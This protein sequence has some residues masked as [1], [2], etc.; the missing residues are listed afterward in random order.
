MTSEVLVPWLTSQ[1]FANNGQPLAGGML[2]SYQAGT[3]TPI[4]TFTDSTGLVQNTNPVG[5]NARGEM[6]VWITNNV[7]YRF[8]LQ[9]SDGNQLWT[10]DQVTSTQL[11]S[12]YGGVD[13]GSSSLYLLN[14]LSPFTSYA[15]FQGTPIFFIPANNSAQGASI[16][17]NG[18]GVVGIYNAN[19][20]TIGP[21]QIQSSFIT[22]IVYQQ[23]IGTSGNSGFV[24]LISGSVTG[25]QVGTFGQ[26]VPIASATTTD[27]GTL[28]AHTGFVTGNTTITSF[29]TSAS[30]LAPFY[31]IRFSAS[32]T[33]T[34]SINLT[35]PG[36]ASIV[37][38]PGDALLAQYLGGV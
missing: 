33:L 6:S 14:F 26:E 37:T 2:W 9:D 3:S 25:S 30:L 36:N 38:Q 24:L 32:L 19:G 16:N 34:N 7:A 31:L 28:P 23:N 15:Q 5:A 29:G 4:A 21:N 1:F 22:E 17:V 8:I 10:R 20:T 12:L 35:L 18:I 13:T 11:L 27:L